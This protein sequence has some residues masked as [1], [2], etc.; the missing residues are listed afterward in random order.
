M[1]MSATGIVNID[2][3]DD[4][5]TLLYYHNYISV[6][7]YSEDRDLHLA[8]AAS[9][10]FPA[11]NGSRRRIIDVSNEYP[12]DDDDVKVIASRTP[13][14]K[15]R[16]KTFTI[17]ETG[18]SSHSNSNPSGDAV[19][20]STFMCEI[21]VEPKSF[22]ESFRIMGCSHSYCSDCMIKYVA[23]KLQENITLIGCPVS[24]CEGLLEPEHCRPILPPE[25]FDRWGSALCE[26]VILGSEKF[27]CPFKDCSALL[28]D[29]PE[30]GEV[31]I[32]SE[33]PY[34]HRLFCA[35]CKVAW[36]LGIE[37]ADFQKLNKNER[38]REDIMLMQLAKNK[39]WIRCPKC[40]FY[41]ERSEG[42]LFMLC[43]WVLSLSANS[44]SLSTHTEIVSH[45]ESIILQSS[46]HLM[47]LLVD[48]CGMK[49]EEERNGNHKFISQRCFSLGVECL[50][51]K[52]KGNLV[53]HIL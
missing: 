19:Y 37:C 44:S 22:N 27:Y 51:E 16:K 2:D 12:T 6:E 5:M 29:D 42:C 26:A 25:V 48:G 38:E 52:L 41:V 34:C 39:K 3:E 50:V 31:I 32:Q 18:E 17:A 36:H 14:P 21:C 11:P 9:L 10:S 35:Q 53:S 40:R 23:S 15:R 13:N 33:C 28:I 47:V 20:T 24:G 46:G 30:N 4:D 8:I 7:Q 45:L 1:G 43:R 49:T